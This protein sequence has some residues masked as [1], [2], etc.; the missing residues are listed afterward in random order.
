MAAPSLNQT[1]RPR[2]ELTQ[3]QRRKLKD[4]LEKRQIHAGNWLWKD[5]ETTD[6]GALIIRGKIKLIMSSEFPDPQMSLGTYGE[7][8]VVLDKAYLTGKGS[9]TSAM[10]LNDAE[11]LLISYQNL[12][13]ILQ[14]DPDL[15]QHLYEMMLKALFNQLEIAYD[16]YLFKNALLKTKSTL[17]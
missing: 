11:V 8:A 3:S 10:V 15:A 14:I 1:N 16:T 7:G 12:H 17:S 2:T 6:H 4:I 5:G 13:A 9:S